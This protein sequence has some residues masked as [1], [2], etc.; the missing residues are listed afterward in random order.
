MCFLFGFICFL[1]TDCLSQGFGLMKCINLSPMKLP[2]RLTFL[3]ARGLV[4]DGCLAQSAC[5]C[6]D[7]RCTQTSAIS[8]Q[9]RSTLRGRESH[10]LFA[11]KQAIRCMWYVHSCATFTLLCVGASQGNTTGAGVGIGQLETII[12]GNFAFNKKN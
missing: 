3:V 8:S 9:V 10:V 6:R 1:T 5:A 7:F 4:P 11:H 12:C 2:P